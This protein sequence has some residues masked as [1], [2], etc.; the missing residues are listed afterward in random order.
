V[1]GALFSVFLAILGVL[2]IFETG[3]HQMLLSAVIDSYRVFVPGHLPP[4]DDLSRVVA[5]V[6]SD[7]FDL[8]VRMAAPFLVMALVFYL[9]LGLLGRL[10]PQIQVFF[11]ALPLQIVLGFLVLMVSVAAMLA[12]F[13]GAFE[14]AISTSFTGG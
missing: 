14:D 5:R 12:W 11:I 4:L 9:G 7:S 6:V 10:M 3:L 1:Q 2:V 8:A 13:A